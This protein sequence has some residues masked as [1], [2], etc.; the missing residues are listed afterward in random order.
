MALLITHECINCDVCEPECPNAAIYQGEEIYEIA[1]ARC[2]ECVGHF[3][4][5]QCVEVCPVDCII[6]DPDRVE[7]ETIL[8][9]RYHL[10]TS[11]RTDPG[12]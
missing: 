6:V 5:S 1:P 8:L 12:S 4:K 7:D 10:L 11:P 9:R 2:T 3:E